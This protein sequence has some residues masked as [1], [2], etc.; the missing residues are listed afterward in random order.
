MVDHITVAPD[1]VQKRYT[2]N[3][4]IMSLI[5][6]KMKKTVDEF[7]QGEISREQFHKIYEHYQSQM[8]MAAQMIAEADTLATIT[9]GETV[10]LRRG[11]T[12]KAKAVTIYYH[13]TGLLLETIG[14]FDAPVA[15]ISPMLNN[16]GGQTQRGKIMPTH[17]EKF[18]DEW[19]LYVPGRY[20]TAV[21]QLSNEPAV[22]QIAIL[23]GMHRDFETANDT[24]LKSGDADSAMLVYPF[25][26]FVRRSV[27]KP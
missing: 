18:R 27:R 9:P 12:A 4:D 24:A 20:T 21:L 10:A 8:V 14:D 17:S 19:L 6:A 2:Q 11:L 26:S 15:L 23:E 3:Q 16:I 1:S 7:A 25:Q 22:R 13:A 5:Q